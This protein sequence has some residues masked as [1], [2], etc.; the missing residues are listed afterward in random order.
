MR[1][2]F[3]GFRAL[4]AAAIG[5]ALLAAPGLA[6]CQTLGLEEGEK[7][8]ANMPSNLSVDAFLW[9]GAL[10]T[11]YFLPITQQD[12]AAGRIETG[13]KS[14]SGDPAEEV[15]VVVQIYPGPVSINSVAVAAYRRVNGTPTGVDPRTA[16]IVQEA[17]LHRARQLKASIEGE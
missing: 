17:I 6:G 13:W 10:D 3:A 16:P 9:Q 4:R 14:V 1:R 5:V 11:L 8:L 15:R 12:P 7:T 2:D